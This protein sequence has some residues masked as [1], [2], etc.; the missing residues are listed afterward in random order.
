MK[1]GV[2]GG[3]AELVAEFRSF[4]SVQRTASPDSPSRVGQI[5]LRARPAYPVVDGTIDAID[6]IGASARTM[7]GFRIADHFDA[8]KD[9]AQQWAPS[10]CRIDVRLLNGSWTPVGT[11]FVTSTGAGG[12]TR[13]LTAGHVAGYLIKRNYRPS[14][15]VVRRLEVPPKFRLEEG[16]V[17][18]ARAVFAENPNGAPGQ[19]P[20]IETI[21][22]AHKVW[23]LMICELDAD[24]GAPPLPLET[25]PAWPATV[26]EPVA[27]LGYPIEV[28]FMPPELGQDGFAEV[29][30]GE[31]GIKRLSPGLL[32]N[33]EPQPVPLP[34]DAG[35]ADAA[36]RILEWAE[37][38]AL[39]HDAS[40]LRGSSGSPVFSLRTGK[41]VS[42]HYGGG[43]YF[44]DGSAKSVAD[45]ANRSV[46]LALAL[47]EARL[48]EEIRQIF[49]AT[50][51]SA[52]HFLGGSG[53][54]SRAALD[55]DDTLESRFVGVAVEDLPPAALA[56]VAHDRPDDR[57]IW[58]TPPL[59]DL[60]NAVLPPLDPHRHIFNQG[61]EA[62]CV[63]CALAAAID[64]LR[65]R[66][67]PNAERVSARMLQEMALAHDEWIEDGAGG[68]SLR[69]A[70]KGLH[71]SGV[72]HDALAPYYPGLRN[73]QLGREAADDAR[74]VTLG[75]Y[76]RLRHR[77]AD[78]QAAIREVGV[79]VVAAQFHDGWLR[80][81]GRRVG[82]IRPSIQPRRR[83]RFLHAFLI[84][85]YDAEGFIIQNSWGREWGAWKSREG[86]AHWSYADWSDN[87]VDAWVLQMAPT[88]PAGFDFRVAGGRAASAARD[89]EE[90]PLPAPLASLPRPRRYQLLGHVAR[91]ERDGVVTSGRLGL[92]IAALRE[93]GLELRKAVTEFPDIALLYHDPFLGEE[94]LGR[95][96]AHLTDGFRR[97]AIYPLHIIYGVDEVE[98]IKVRM[99]AEA[100]IVEKRFAG[101]AAEAPDYLERRARRLCAALWGHYEAGVQAAAERYGS[102]WHATAAFCIEA[103]RGR[104]LHMIGLGTG[105]VAMLAQHAVTKCEQTQ[106]IE[107]VLAVAGLSEPA[108]GVAVTAWRLALAPAGAALPGY[109][110]DWVDLV[111]AIRSG[112]PLPH[113]GAADARDR[114]TTG[115]GELASALVNP[116]ILNHLVRAIRGALP[117]PT[118]AFR[119]PPRASGTGPSTAVPS[120]R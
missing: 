9:I 14:K 64:L 85:G 17:A 3:D 45:H 61:S 120:R 110:R 34:G 75:A 114:S 46:N 106:K 33:A 117:P 27:V 37:E 18:D 90:A 71:A 55:S 93:A 91:V 39:K 44:K 94:A 81:D 87:C 13:I 50:G 1:P 7:L 98:T 102:L 36:K 119:A 30:P 88:A 38:S 116:K 60:P 42:L 47:D 100:R 43:S 48:A 19:G 32:T 5:I 73:W 16:N 49:P 97:N 70:I 76:Y 68:T 24:A 86:L 21:V 15:G 101:A 89:A 57:D 95:L 53:S 63:G 78:F 83:C 35:G 65:R 92:G 2:T 11:G 4:L 59:I 72:C 105:S 79:V 12:R 28:G 62:S 107:Q 82:R 104:R 41:V 108:E 74:S 109:P 111:H 96:A 31:L 22:W 10:V 58:Y 66:T 23:D 56:A 112:G 52:P 99:T 51:P 6:A 84:V 54:W 80:R 25:D 115:D 8:L 69:A 118:R 67:T 26:Q 113:R 40:T 77:L 20:G 29:L 103:A